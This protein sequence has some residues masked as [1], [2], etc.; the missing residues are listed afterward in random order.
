MCWQVGPVCSEGS[1][2]VLLPGSVS[3]VHRLPTA[4]GSCGF[5]A[6]VCHFAPVVA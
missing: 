1:H 2:P 4:V 6:P 3:R 5:S